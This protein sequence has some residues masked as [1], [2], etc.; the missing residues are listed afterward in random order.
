MVA[1]SED[2]TDLLR[3]ARAVMALQRMV[4]EDTDQARMGITELR[5]AGATLPA[6][7]QNT[8]LDR[9]ISTGPHPPQHSTAVRDRGAAKSGLPEAAARFAPG[10]TAEYAMCMM[11][12]GAWIFITG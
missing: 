10:P 5:L 7:R 8:V 9:A 6:E 11:A 1:V 4:R 2:N 12:D 3:S